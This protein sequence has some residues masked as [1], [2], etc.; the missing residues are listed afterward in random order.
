MQT[1]STQ[2]VS[3]FRPLFSASWHRQVLPIAWRHAQCIRYV[4]WLELLYLRE[5][6]SICLLGLCE[7][8][9]L[10]NTWSHVTEKAPLR[11]S[12]TTQGNPI[13]YSTD[14]EAGVDCG[15]AKCSC[16]SGVTWPTNM[17]SHTM[18]WKTTLQLR[19]SPATKGNPISCSTSVQIGVAGGMANCGW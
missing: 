4:C 15:M 14:L 10:S 11:N 8:I 6:Q 16:L 13:S 3:C 7:I 1:T 18:T 12:L 19:N 9:W 2:V 17:W 5:R